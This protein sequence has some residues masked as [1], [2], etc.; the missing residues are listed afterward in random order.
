VSA[1]AAIPIDGDGGLAAGLAAIDCQ[2]NG[3]VQAGYAQLFGASGMFG[4]VLRAMLVVW[5]AVLALGLIGGRLR[6]SLPVLGPRLF[7]VALVLTFATAWP[8]YQAVVYGLLVGGPDQ[9]A[10]ALL[11]MTHGATQAFASRLDGLLGDLVEL[12]RQFDAQAAAPQAKQAAKLVRGC[13]LVLLLSTVGLLVVARLVLAALLAL[14][15]VFVLLALFRATRGLFEGWLRMALS[16]AL[17]PMLVALA[18]AVVLRVLAPVIA[19]IALDP[20]AAAQQLRPLLMLLLG[21]AIYL[22]L[23]L[24]MAW[25]AAGLTRTWR[26]GRGDPQAA[27]AAS[28]GASWVDLP[29]GLGAA[30]APSARVHG[31]AAEAR[32]ASAGS[33]RTVQWLAGLARD[34]APRTMPQALVAAPSVGRRRGGLGQGL[35]PRMAWRP[36][37]GARTP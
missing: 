31:A 2:I 4:A 20:L 36:L 7:G 13:A 11:G 18:G 33:A 6:L 14:G 9:I 1:C 8:A 17:V 21:C 5:V 23:L 32:V 16:F 19:A 34:G 26:L 29:A 24:A 35:R 22:G 28:A 10:S 27:G 37:G 3:A 25:T 15:P 30:S 12:G